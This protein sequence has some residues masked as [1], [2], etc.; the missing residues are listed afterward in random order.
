M[1]KFMKRILVLALTLSMCAT[2]LTACTK[3]TDENSSTN[4]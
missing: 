1:K 3:K 2:F 4:Q